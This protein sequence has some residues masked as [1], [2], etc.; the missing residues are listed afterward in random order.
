LVVHP[1]TRRHFHYWNQPLNMRICYPDCHEAWLCCYLVI[2]IENL[3]RPLHCFTSIY[4]LF[5]GS[6]LY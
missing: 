6:T 4:D 2:N 3:L 5:I 1:Q